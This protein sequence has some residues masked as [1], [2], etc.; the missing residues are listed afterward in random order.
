MLPSKRLPLY[1]VLVV[2]TLFKMPFL[3]YAFYWDECYP[4]VVAIKDLHQQG[5][6]LLPGAIDPELSKGHP[7]FFHSIASL[8]MYLFGESNRSLHT[9]ALTISLLCLIAVYE[10]ALKVFNQRVAVMSLIL[11]AVQTIFIVQSSF[12][13]PEVLIAL[14]ALMCFYLYTVNRFILSCIFL[15]MLFYSKES[16]M[17]VGIVLGTHAFIA[18]F[19]KTELLKTRILR[20]LST[21]V[22]FIAIGVFFVLQKQ[23]RGWYLYPEHTN[24]IVTQW[25]LYFY[26]FKTKCMDT[27]FVMDQRYYY[28]VLMLVVS[29]IAAVKNKNYKYLFIFIQAIFTFYAVDDMRS[30]RIL[31]SIPFSILFICSV[32]FM[33]YSL[34]KLKIIEDQRQIQFITLIISFV[35]VFFC[36]S[37]M[38]FFTPRYMIIAIIPLLI[39]CAVLTEKTIRLSYSILYYP[40]LA[41]I[42]FIGIFTYFTTTGNG[43]VQP[44]AFDAVEVQQK[45]VDYFEKNQL[46]DKTIGCGSFLAGK[47]LQL[48]ATGFL[49]NNRPFKNTSWGIDN[50]TDYAVFDNLE[51]DDRYKIVA[52]SPFF[53]RVYRYE[54]NGIWTEI[55]QA[56]RP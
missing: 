53:H 30:G 51:P 33:L 24:M 27:A 8:W 5:T 42:A 47:H 18:L 34:V 19:N 43:D 49:H 17:I 36:F 13:L 4:Y 15:A 6:S 12:V 25:F 54:K 10:I 38:N 29:A 26:D 50:K 44:G 1:C 16:G 48:P 23:L 56:N 39:F 37:A 32:I 11:V 14:L 21:V 3:N 7:L 31:P 35:F 40:T 46:Y 20:I 28:F 45:R 9:F 22:P 55:Y 2:F 41:L 52:N